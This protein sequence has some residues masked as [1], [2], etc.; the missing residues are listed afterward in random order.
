MKD[1][2]VDVMQYFEGA[3][4]DAA[5]T[6]LEVATEI[7]RRRTSTRVPRVQTPKDPTPVTE[8]QTIDPP[9][10]PKA[11]VRKPKSESPASPLPSKAEQ[12]LTLPGVVSTVGD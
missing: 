1:P 10:P 3:S 11:R 5:K 2:I 12:A 7:V 4:I 8:I 6:A 9:A